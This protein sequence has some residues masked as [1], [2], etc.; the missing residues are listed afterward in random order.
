MHEVYEM[1]GLSKPPFR[2]EEDFGDNTLTP[3]ADAS[4]GDNDDDKTE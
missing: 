1:L 3:N 4:G 2:E